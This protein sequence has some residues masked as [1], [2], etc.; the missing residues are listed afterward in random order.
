MKFGVL[1]AFKF[2]Q[3]H[4]FARGSTVKQINFNAIALSGLL[5]LVTI[6]EG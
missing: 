2:Q 6:V 5:T 4:D 1:I 3:V